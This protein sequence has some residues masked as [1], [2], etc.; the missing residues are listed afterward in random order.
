MDLFRKIKVYGLGRVISYVMPELKR[1][2]R[3]LFLGSYSH[4]GEDLFLSKQFTKNYKGFYVDVGTNDPKR[5]NNSYYFYKRG[6]RGINIEPDP[7]CFNKIQKYR[8]R[9]INL[10][11]GVGENNGHLDFYL[12]FPSILNTFSKKQSEEYVSQGYELLEVKKV[13]V[14]KLEDV[15]DEYLPEGIEIDFMSIDAEGYDLNVLKGLN[16]LRYKPK[17]ICIEASKEDISDGIYDMLRENDYSEVYSS[18]SNAIFKDGS[19]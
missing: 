13:E 10:N 12:F 15:L 19:K 14:R 7:N 18:G 11:I 2:F 6:W 8:E 5:K 9:D 16:I 17:Y 3:L 4:L 1:Y